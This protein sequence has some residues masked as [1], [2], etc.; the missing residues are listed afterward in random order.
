MSTVA[1]VPDR[2]QRRS[3][4]VMSTVLV[5]SVHDRQQ[6]QSCTLHRLSVA[7]GNATMTVN[8]YTGMCT[9][10]SGSSCLPMVLLTFRVVELDH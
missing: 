5:A 1:S 9:D 8:S 6:G 4:Q 10:C 7:R 3:S 2:Q